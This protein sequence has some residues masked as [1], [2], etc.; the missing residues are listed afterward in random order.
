[1]VRAA[2]PALAPPLVAA[3]GSSAQEVRKAVVFALVDI[4]LALGEEVMQ[5]LRDLTP[6]QQKLLLMY[7]QRATS[8]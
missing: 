8:R 6:A 5:H 1:V 3:F 7:V 2:L 4:Y